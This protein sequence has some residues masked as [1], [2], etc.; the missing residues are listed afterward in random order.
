MPRRVHASPP[1]SKDQTVPLIGEHP[2]HPARLRRRNRRLAVLTW[3]ATIALTVTVLP[4]CVSTAAAQ[5]DFY[6][7]TGAT[8]LAKLAPG[9]VLRTRTLSYHVL[10][11]PTPLTAIQIAYRSTDAL[12]APTVNVTSVIKPPVATGTTKVVAFESAYD[13][14]YSPD[15]PSRAIAGD[16]PLGGLTPGGNL[17]VGGAS[18]S[19]EA[20]MFG[21]LLLQGYTVVIADIEGQKAHFGAGPEYG[22]NTLDSLR[23]AS[24][25]RDTGIGEHTKVALMGYSGGAIGASWAAALAPSYAPDINRRLIGSAIG[26]LLVAPVRN[27]AYTGGSLAWSGPVIMAVF[28][29]ADAYHIDLTP[30]LSDYGRQIRD[31]MRDAAPA[32]VWGWYPGLTWAKLMKLEYADPASI[33][34]FAAVVD[35]LDL[36]HAPTP[37]TPMLVVEGANG[38]LEGTPPGGRGIG[39]GDGVM[40]AGDVRTLA[41]KY[42]AAG[43]PIWYQQHDWASHTLAGGMWTLQAL[44]W[45]NDRFAGTSVP[46]NC[47]H[48]PAGNNLTTH[49]SR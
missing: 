19:G 11:V 32:T 31:R 46:S 10:N 38:I 30:Y 42:C 1:E 48:V 37:T 23:A 18:A 45:I 8:P 16:T 35:K 28:G 39:P 6:T 21:P 34:A 40:I 15:S 43:V 41:N 44:Q 49:T 24:Q 2:H 26:G 9:A 17:Q 5:P 14:R 22:T 7:A 29:I 47:G 13:S 4:P 33:P 20:G 12:G 27:L 25:V 3:I 36:T